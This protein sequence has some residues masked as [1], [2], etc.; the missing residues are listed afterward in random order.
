M[1]STRDAVDDTVAQ[2]DSTVPDLR[3]VPSAVGAWIACGLGVASGASAAVV[4]AVAFVTMAA[5]CGL[6][7]AATG[8]RRR[9]VTVAAAALV[10]TAAF[11]GTAAL[12]V[13]AVDTGPVRA[14]AEAGRSVGVD[15][16]VSEDPREID[17]AGATLVVLSVRAHRVASGRDAVTGPADLTVLATG[18]EWMRVA[19]GTPVTFRARLAVPDRPGLVA[20]VAR[21]TGPPSPGIPPW[22]AAAATAVRGALTAASERA[23]PPESAGLLPGIVVGDRSGLLPDVEEDFT[24]AGMSHLTAVSGA[25]FAFLVGAVVLL[26]RACTLGPRATVLLA[27]LALVAFVVIA[28]PSPSVLRAAVMGVI[29][30]LA[31]LTGRR[32]HAMP[33][34]ATAVIVLLAVDPALAVSWGFALSVTATAALVLLAPVLLRWWVGDPDA[35]DGRPARSP[36]RGAVVVAVAAHLVTAPIVAAM[37]GR[38][39]LYAVVA[40]V[41]AAPV[42]GPVT[43]VGAAAAL[44]GVVDIDVGALVAGV[45]RLPLAWLVEVARVCASAPGAVIPTPDG[46]AG[47]LVVGAIAV[48]AIGVWW[49]VR[50]RGG[51]EGRGCRSPVARSSGE[52]SDPPRAP[53]SRPG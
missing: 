30:L 21:P 39:S 4:L 24:E 2:Q 11:A 31:L 10:V 37:A 51:R 49:W 43:V 40:N 7:S 35:P 27:G 28:R 15:G 45:T 8:S 19:Y 44:I 42:V 46:L 36:V 18:A 34:L 29:G 48:G 25:N 47:A 9:V 16:V 20:A 1:T 32:R 22:W 41:L 23:L 33:A 53:S 50:A 5:G 52:C 6:W 12:R 13:D 17:G 3:L 38:S 26:A 14:Y